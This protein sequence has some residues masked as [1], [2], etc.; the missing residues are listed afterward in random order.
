LLLTLLKSKIH[1]ATVTDTRADY[2]GSVSVDPALMG[3]AGILEHERL[4][5]ANVSNGARFETYCIAGGE[6]EVTVNGAAA[7]LAAKGDK[8][9]IMAFCSLS[10][11]EASLHEPGVVLVDDLNKPISPEKP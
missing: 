4:L 3:A 7:R 9:I 8:V 5:V 11:E 2:A 6:G 10:P 1:R